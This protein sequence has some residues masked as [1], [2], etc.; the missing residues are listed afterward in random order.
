MVS[1]LDSG[2]S[3]P[4]SSLSQG[5]VL[6]YWVRHFTLI[7]PLFTQ[8][9][10]LVP[11]TLLLGVTLRWQGTKKFNFP[12]CPSGKLQPRCASPEVISS[13]P[14]NFIVLHCYC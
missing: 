9:Y 8:V 6:C 1:A 12:A 5:T 7:V 4:G 3:G 14:E 10:N 11:A 2:W 13:S